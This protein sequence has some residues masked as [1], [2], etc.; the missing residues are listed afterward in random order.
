MIRLFHPYICKQAKENVARV[1]DSGWLG[2]GPETEKFEQEFARYIGCKHAVAVNSGTEA[3]HLS[4]DALRLRYGR[5]ITT[6]NTFVSTNHVIVQAGLFPYFADI[7]PHTGSLDLYS[8]EKALKRHIIEGIMVVHYGGMPVDLDGFRGLSKKYGIPLIEDCAHAMGATYKGERIGKDSLIACFSFHAVKNLATGDGG[9]ICT[10]TDSIAEFLKKSRW[11]GID[12]STADRTKENSYSWD[13]N[14]EILGHKAHMNDI[15]AAIGRGQLT[16]LDEQNARRNDLANLYRRLLSGSS[17][18]WLRTYPDRASSNHLFVVRFKN[19]KEKSN[20]I[21]RLEKNSIQFGYHYKPNYLYP[22][23][24]KYRCE[25][26][27]WPGMEEFYA[28]ALSLP[29]HIFLIPANIYHICRSVTNDSF[30]SDANLELPVP[31]LTS[32]SKRN[33]PEVG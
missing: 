33:D 14:V 21:K 11:L 3:L 5:I 31:Y 1:L 32:D 7:D 8:V 13:Y 16:R 23:Y 2:L 10:N 24:S 12:K 30:N 15:T 22:V 26:D 4:L 9:M 17:V 29:M 28:T 25:S 19:A 27:T 20:A 6:P 18:E